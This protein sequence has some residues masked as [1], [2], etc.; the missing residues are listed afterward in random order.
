MIA[1]NLAAVC[2]S[3]MFA[4]KAG[5]DLNKVF[6]V[7]SAGF[8]GSKALNS[9][10]PRILAENYEPGFSIALHLKDLNNA[11]AAGKSVDSPMPLCE[12]MIDVMNEMTELGLSGKDN[13]GIALYYEHLANTKF[14]D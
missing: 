1:N 5:C 7:V 13:S 12:H 11:L 14:V 8:A 3:M 10:V 9:T 6:E 2:E 4:K